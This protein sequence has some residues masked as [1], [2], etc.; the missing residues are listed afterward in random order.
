MERFL[1]HS[2]LKHMVSTAFADVAGF[3]VDFNFFVARSRGIKV[4]VWNADLARLT[5]GALAVC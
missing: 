3:Q 5:S 4:F 1:K 2:V